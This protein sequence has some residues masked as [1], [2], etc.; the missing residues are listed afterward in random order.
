MKE[1]ASVW[2]MNS[3]REFLL[4]LRGPN[5]HNNPNTWGNSA[6]GGI[7]AGETPLQ[8]VRRET[9]EELGLDIPEKN[10]IF[11]GEFFDVKK[12]G[13]E[14]HLHLYFA[15]GD[16]KLSDIKIQKSEI[17]AV[18]YASLVEIKKIIGTLACSIQPQKI[19]LLEKYLGEKNA[20]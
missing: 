10:F 7:D 20:D 17:T 6:G 15:K 18:E 9:L 4:Q 3:D 11:L 8:A 14:K 1:T 5:Q 2:I 16:Y 12:S 19:E 13:K